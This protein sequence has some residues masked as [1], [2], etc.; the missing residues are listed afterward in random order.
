MKRGARLPPGAPLSLRL[1]NRFAP[2]YWSLA[3]TPGAV[4]PQVPGLQVALQPSHPAKQWFPVPM[5]CWQQQVPLSASTHSCEEL[6][7]ALSQGLVG[8]GQSASRLQHP[9]IGALLHAWFTQVSVV[10]AFESSHSPSVLQ[11]PGMGS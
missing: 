8:V 5:N 10:Q 4:A 3:H 11:H 9:V 7:V 1:R 2:G 6:H